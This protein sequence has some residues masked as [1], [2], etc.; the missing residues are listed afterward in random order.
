MTLMLVSTLV[1]QNKIGSPT[2][3]GLICKP[4]GWG[5]EI[6]TPECQDQ[7][8]VP[9][10]LATPQYFRQFNVSAGRVLV[11]VDLSMIL[12]RGIATGWCL[13]SAIQRMVNPHNHGINQVDFILKTHFSQLEPASMAKV[14]Y[15]C[16][17]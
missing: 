14:Q 8:L 16:C 10:H 12:L 4:I 6:R 3:T 13:T 7:N 2:S 17:Y 1:L 11:L 15:K 5:G 9:Y